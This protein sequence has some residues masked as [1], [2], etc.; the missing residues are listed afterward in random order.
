VTDPQGAVTRVSL[1]DAQSGI[2]LDPAL[3]VFRDPGTFG[4]GATR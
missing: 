3:F 2:K 4:E 1:S